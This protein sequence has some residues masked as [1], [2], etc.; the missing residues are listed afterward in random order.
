M[1]VWLPAIRAGSGADI[2]TSRLADGLK[3]IGE[4]ACITWF[5]HYCEL[6]PDLLRLAKPPR[7]TD[8]VQ[9]NSWTGFAFASQSLPLVVTVHHCVHDE[10][11]AP[12]RTTAQGIYHALV[13]R[14]Y[15]SRSFLRA[16][17]VVAV[18]Q[19]TA[20]QVSRCFKGVRPLV[21]HNGVDTD[22][23]CPGTQGSTHHGMPFRIL[24]VGNLSRRKGAD[25]LV[26]I[27]DTLGTQ[28]ALAYSGG[29]RGGRLPERPNIRHL[30][31]LSTEDLRAAYRECDAVLYP[32]RYEGFGYVPCEAMACGKPVVAADIGGVREVVAHNETGILC[33][34]NDTCA[35]ADALRTLALDRDM[36]MEMGAAGRHRAV[37]IFDLA[38]VTRRYAELYRTL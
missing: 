30:G 16:D 27:M 38:A 29:L 31:H 24:Y 32:S 2:F 28:F 5:P 35:F 26:E 23:F 34:V 19:F 1:K 7:D 22:Y 6:L 25:R 14:P 12:Y 17:R 9:A 21:I 13:V 15:E 36:A 10:A 33:P 11:F 8:V 37:E 18:S 20:D 3:R 4:S